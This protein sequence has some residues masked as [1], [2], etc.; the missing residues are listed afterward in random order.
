[1]YNLYQS[2]L[3]QDIQTQVYQKEH[4]TIKLFDKEYFAIQKSKKVGPFV[5]KRYQI[6]WVTLP[7]NEKLVQEELKRLKSIYGKDRTNISFQLG[8]NNE[9]ISFENVSHRSKDFTQD[10][11]QMRLNIRS[12]ITKT[13]GLRVTVRENMPQCDII[14]D[15]SKSD[16]QLL[17]EMNSWAKERIK[18]WMKKWVKFERVTT[19]QY[20]QFYGYWKEIAWEKGFNIIPY[21]QFTKLVDYIKQNKKGDLFITRI[22]EHILAWSVCLFDDHRIVYYQWFA[23]RDKKLRNIWWH[24]YLKFEIM[25]R[26]RENGFTYV[27]MMWGAPTGFPEHPLAWVTKFKESL[28]W[29]KIEE[30]GSYDLVL[31]PLLYKAFGR[32]TNLKHSK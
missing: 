18:K 8:M 11:K 1:M 12:Y 29:I 30:Y 19:D 2:Q 4:F 7:D 10:M 31:N 9:I 16:E 22:D 21:N 3:R 6:M 5:L 14:Y 17:W 13:Y 24:A 20:E 32:Y 15:I 26:A 27:D 23:N 28:W 25:R